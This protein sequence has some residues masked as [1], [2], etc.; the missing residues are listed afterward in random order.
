MND[1]GRT[2]IGRE[3]TVLG[4]GVHHLGGLAWSWWEW[5]VLPYHTSCPKPNKHTSVLS[6]FYI[7]LRYGVQQTLEI[8]FK[9]YFEDNK[10]E[11]AKYTRVN[12][13]LRPK[14]LIISA[15]NDDSCS[16]TCCLLTKHKNVGLGMCVLCQKNITTGWHEMEYKA[17]QLTF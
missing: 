16:S 10:C 5:T 11:K 14:G 8:W 4:L 7:N 2:K 9:V 3:Q 12:H 13:S 1:M 15:S 6:I 17:G